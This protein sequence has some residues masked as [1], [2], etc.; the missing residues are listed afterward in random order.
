MRE[1]RSKA[2]LATLQSNNRN[3]DINTI[4]LHG[5]TVPEAKEFITDF[6]NNWTR[7]E[8]KKG[9]VRVITGLGNH[10]E[11][12]SKLGPAMKSFFRKLGWQIEEGTGFLFVWP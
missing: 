1:V 9:K 8:R 3:S 12:G 5:L 10:S 11:S 4:D 2:A 6:I 7:N